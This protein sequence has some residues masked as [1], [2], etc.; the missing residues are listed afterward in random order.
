MTTIE[1]KATRLNRGH[2]QVSSNEQNKTSNTE[3][4]GHADSGFSLVQ[5]GMWKQTKGKHGAERVNSSPSFPLLK[6]N[7]EKIFIS[8]SEREGSL[9]PPPYVLPGSRT[10]TFSPDGGSGTQVSLT[11]LS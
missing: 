1:G 11:W 5:R 7:E 4:Q 6:E 9:T 10:I 3:L 8:G 2:A